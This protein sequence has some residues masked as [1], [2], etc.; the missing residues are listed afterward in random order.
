MVIQSRATPPDWT[1]E[2][3]GGEEGARCRRFPMHRDSDG[4]VRDDTWFQDAE[5]ALPICN[6]D[7][8]GSPCPVRSSCLVWA[9]LNNESHGVFGGM[10]VPQRR[11]IR[12]NVPR[13][14]WSD[15]RWLREVVPPPEYFGNLG[16]ED[17]DADEEAFRAEQEE[18]RATSKEA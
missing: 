18:L 15:D 7:W 5:E 1:D 9:L 13:G 17:P 3:G 2:A 16:D 11:W 4:F 10:T 12:R 14:R 6:G 8:I